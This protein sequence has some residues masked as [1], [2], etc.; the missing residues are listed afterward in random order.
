MNIKSFLRWLAL[1]FAVVLVW[2]LTWLINSIVITKVCFA[3]NTKTGV[4][5]W[6]VDFI[7]SGLGT[8]AAI[9]VSGDI[10]PKWKDKIAIIIAVAFIIFSIV[11]ITLA[12]IN[13]TNDVVSTI[14]S[15]IGVIAFAIY[16]I[17]NTRKNK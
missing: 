8:L 12:L 2:Y 13:G 6:L 3:G 9:Y 4:I 10:S 11:S 16:Y 5:H 14:F 1:P 17:I 7:A 15:C